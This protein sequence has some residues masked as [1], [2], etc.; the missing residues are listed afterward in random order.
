M[1]CLVVSYLVVDFPI[2]ES[3]VRPMK[4]SAVREGTRTLRA[5]S[6]NSPPKTGAP[7]GL[8]S[9][10]LGFWP[11]RGAS[12]SPIPVE[13]PVIANCRP[14]DISKAPAN[15]GAI[16][17]SI[18]LSPVPP[19]RFDNAAEQLVPA[20]LF[21]LVAVEDFK[22]MKALAWRGCHHSKKDGCVLVMK[23]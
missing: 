9:Q 17:K 19:L 11:A 6:K 12:S 3:K 18:T 10:H 14:A 2:E 5:T 16:L 22:T 20:R 15:V 4:C 8:G 7:Q 1:S 23:P 13:A 21:I